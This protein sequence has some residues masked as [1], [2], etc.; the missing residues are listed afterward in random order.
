V[1][2]DP[3]G[4]PS[5]PMDGPG[6]AS[7]VPRCALDLN[8]VAAGV[9]IVEA[10]RP[11]PPFASCIWAGRATVTTVTPCVL[12]LN[13]VDARAPRHHQVSGAL[14]CLAYTGVVERYGHTCVTRP[15]RRVA[16]AAGVGENGA[17]A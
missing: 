1:S 16:I 4:P 10:A 11:P 2:P 5:V 12:G 6:D 17:G 13:A 8:A 14:R 9:V 7:Q 15:P 3:H